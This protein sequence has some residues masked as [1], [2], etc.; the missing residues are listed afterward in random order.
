MNGFILGV[1]FTVV[2]G[3]F[4]THINSR[5]QTLNACA[6]LESGL[7]TGVIAALRGDVKRE[8][9]QD[10]PGKLADAM[11]QP[12]G[13]PVIRQKVRSQLEGRGFFGCAWD[14]VR[15]DLLGDA[16]LIEQARSITLRF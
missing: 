12:L 5:Y 10:L 9:G 3:G 16:S 11:L 6:A 1:V 7:T 14:V 4:F 15:L 13:E 8:V 2:I